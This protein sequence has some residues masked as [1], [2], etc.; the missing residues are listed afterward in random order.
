MT[1][2]TIHTGKMEEVLK[3]YP[4][5]Y[6]DSCVSDFPYGYKFMGKKWDYDVPSMEMCAEI[7]RV[8]KPGGYLLAFGGPRTSH[9]IAIN[10]EDAG[11]ELRDT[12]MWIY[13][14]GFPKSM[15]VAKAIDKAH[16]VEP[17][18]IGEKKMWGNN[19]GKGKGGFA[20][21][22][23]E[24]SSGNVK[25]VPETE[26]TSDLAKKFDGW[27]TALKP[28]YEPIIVARKPLIGT[29]AENYAQ[30]GTGGINVDG[31]RIPVDWKSERPESWLKSGK[32]ELSR[33]NPW[34]GEGY[35]KQQSVEDV[36]SDLGRWPANVV[37]D[38]S[39]E[40]LK[41]FPVNETPSGV[42]SGPSRG[43]IGTQ[44]IFSGASGEMGESAFYGDVGSAARFF[45]CAKISPEDRE[46]G[47]EAIPPE[48]IPP[49][50]MAFGNQAIAEMK[51][52]NL[53]HSNGNSGMNKVKVRHNT[54]PTVKPTALMRW[55]V[56]LVTP[57]N[58]TC[59]DCFAGSG[60]TGKAL[61]F[62]Q[63]NAVLIDMD[64][65][66]APIS[67]ARMDWA[68]RHRDNQMKIFE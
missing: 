15:D 31:C 40:V 6:F 25:Y 68:I 14:S 17:T 30:F 55:L 20:S 62:E 65:Q 13:G 5:N 37:H 43:K 23:Y 28:A 47:C 24:G 63:M 52:G 33:A 45:Y 58:G 42:A 21:N 7:F 50:A 46:E 4:D 1:P 34:H 10:I 66:W 12:I 56:R 27:G 59:L 53:D 54:H 3:Q 22:G 38:G 57:K 51:R 41:N 48:A 2:Y 18:V 67:K 8:L 39:D 60:S 26:P 9:R 61:M 44:G 11:F 36:I 19:A 29:I 35:K 64:S 32:G 16:G 49:E